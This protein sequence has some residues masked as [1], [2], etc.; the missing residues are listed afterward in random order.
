MILSIQ[1]AIGRQFLCNQPMKVH[2]DH[3][4][5]KKRFKVDAIPYRPNLTDDENENQK[6][7]LGGNSQLAAWYGSENA[8]FPIHRRTTAS[9]AAN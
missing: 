1:G 5:K 2:K 8:R 9:V 7:F 4:L 3:Y 6:F